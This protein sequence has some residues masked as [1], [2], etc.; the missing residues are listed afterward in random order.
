MG[1]DW[2]H[3]IFRGTFKEIIYCKILN[4]CIKLLS[5]SLASSSLAQ[6]KCDANQSQQ[7]SQNLKTYHFLWLQLENFPIVSLLTLEKYLLNL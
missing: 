6:I 2:K 7:F 3:L 1:E 5:Y 4:E